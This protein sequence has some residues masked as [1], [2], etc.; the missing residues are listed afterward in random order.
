MKTESESFPLHF[1][2]ETKSKLMHNCNKCNIYTNDLEAHFKDDHRYDDIKRYHPG[3]PK[4]KTSVWVT[5]KQI[6][7]N[8]MTLYKSMDKEIMGL[9]EK[10]SPINIMLHK[11]L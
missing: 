1:K 2:P 4:V 5:D 9:K 7:Q 6:A 3:W 10:M 11:S 8:N